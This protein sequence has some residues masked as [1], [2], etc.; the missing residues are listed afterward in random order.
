MSTIVRLAECLAILSLASGME[1]SHSIKTQ[2]SDPTKESG[3]HRE[4]FSPG[5]SSIS[6][7]S[8]EEILAKVRMMGLVKPNGINLHYSLTSLHL[9][10]VDLIC[11]PYIEILC[12]L[13]TL[14]LALLFLD[15]SA[16]LYLSS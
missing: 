14:F 8:S 13:L 5:V 3:Y 15:R 1:F 7:A 9:S 6:P 12:Q 16:M 4:A 2:K 10:Y 11:S